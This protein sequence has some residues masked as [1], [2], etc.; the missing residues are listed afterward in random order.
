VVGGPTLTDRVR[1]A[2]SGAADR[3]GDPEGGLS[4]GPLGTFGGVQLVAVFQTPS[5]RFH[6]AVPAKALAA[7]KSRNAIVGAITNKREILRC[8]QG[9]RLIEVPRDEVVLVS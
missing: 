5:V 3:V 7:A 6:I 8:R 2:V 1:T 4:F 9:D